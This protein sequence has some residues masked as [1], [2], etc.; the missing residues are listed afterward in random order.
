MQCRMKI[1]FTSFFFLCNVA[2]GL[3]SGAWAALLRAAPAA[4]RG[5]SRVGRPLSCLCPANVLR[6]TAPQ[7]VSPERA[8]GA[9][10][11]GFPGSGRRAHVAAGAGGGWAPCHLSTPRRVTTRHSDRSVRT[12]SRREQARTQTHARFLAVMLFLS[13]TLTWPASR[14]RKTCLT[15]ARSRLVPPTRVHWPARALVGPQL[16]RQ[17]GGDLCETREA[18]PPG[19]ETCR[20]PCSR[21]AWLSPWPG[22]NRLPWVL[23]LGTQDRPT[24]ALGPDL[25]DPSWS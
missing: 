22:R 4:S 1:D 21:R 14:L 13:K 2:T 15:G 5:A 8:W 25:E 10:N 11:G 3:R 18:G 23:S 16:R 12:R 20:A 19:R 7:S 24:R 9:G 17:A 6:E